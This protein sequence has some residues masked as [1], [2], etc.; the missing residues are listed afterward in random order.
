MPESST[1]K[2]WPVMGTGEPGTGI[3]ICAASAVTRLAPVTS[4]MSRR[5]PARG[6]ATSA[7]VSV[8]TEDMVTSRRARGAGPG[9]EPGLE[10]AAGPGEQ[11]GA[12]RDRAK[13][14]PAPAGGQP[15]EMGRSAQQRD[16]PGHR[17][18]VPAEAHPIDT[19]RE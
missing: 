7:R 2:V 8:R 18:E 5:A 15:L 3:A 4:R 13:V 12:W 1:A 17:T 11:D 14:A 19:G 9:R 6:K 10:P 16:P